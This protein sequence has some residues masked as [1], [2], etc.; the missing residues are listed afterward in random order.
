MFA[1][2]LIN[3]ASAFIPNRI[4]VTPLIATRQFVSTDKMI[5]TS[6]PEETREEGAMMSSPAFKILDF[7][8]S[9]PIIHDLMFGVYRKQI[10]EKS[11]KMGL[12][13]TEFMDEQWESLPDLQEKAIALTNP[14]TKIPDYY[15]A[16]IHG[17]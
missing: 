5:T 4:R 14:Q 10:V 13:W 1:F 17:K 3:H 15:Y 7:I 12:P 2:F 8:M 16:P 6:A 9:I 11:E